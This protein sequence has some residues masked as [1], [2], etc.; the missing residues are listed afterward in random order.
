M[1]QA[2]FDSECSEFYEKYYFMKFDKGLD[3]S[4]L[5]ESLAKAEFSEKNLNL[6]VKYSITCNIFSNIELNFGYHNLN[7]NFQYLYGKRFQ[8]FT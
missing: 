5:F 1:L 8:I 4:K 6:P 2:S 7:T 3:S